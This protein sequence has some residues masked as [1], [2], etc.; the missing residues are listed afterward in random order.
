MSKIKNKNKF[1]RL[2]YEYESTNKKIVVL[3]PVLLVFLGIF[4][5]WI[6]GSPLSTLHFVGAKNLIPPI[7]LMVLLFCISYTVAG[8]GFGLGLGKRAPYCEAKKYQGAMW[9][10][11]SLATGYIWYPIFFC[12]RLFLVSAALCGICLFTSICATFC[13][14]RVSKISFFLLLLYDCWLIYLTLLNM[15]IFFAI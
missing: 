4:T 12:A 8:L 15:Q 2:R 11:I 10:V 1:S 5:R 3:M 9:F 14:V 7:W 13:F 6:S